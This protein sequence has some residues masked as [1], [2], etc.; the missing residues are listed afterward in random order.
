MEREILFRGIDVETGKFVYGYLIEG[1]NKVVE[2]IHWEGV[3][4]KNS[5]VVAPKSV[6]QFTGLTDK[7]GVKIFEGDNV[8]VPYNHIG[9][10]EVKYLTKELRFNISSYNL[11][12]ITVIGNIHEKHD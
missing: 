11:S 8:L 3:Y 5:S 9:I 10:I 7:N 2:I 12:S 6:G 4:G 1:Y